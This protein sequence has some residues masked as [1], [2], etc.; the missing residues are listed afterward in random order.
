[1][2]T[3]YLCSYWLQSNTNGRKI[4]LMNTITLQRSVAGLLTLVVISIAFIT[5]QSASALSC[6][7]PSEMIKHYV[8]EASYTV[9]LIKAGA[10]E[11]E[12]HTHDQEVTVVELYKGV[13]GTNETVSFPYNET[14]SYLCAGGPVEEGVE[15]IYIMKD[16][17]VA[18]VF[19]VDSELA[20]EL[21]T[22]LGTEPTE[23]T[24]PTPEEETKTEATTGLMQRVI[25]L[26][27]Q[28][29]S[30]LTNTPL[31]VADDPTEMDVEQNYVG[32]TTKEAQL[33]AAAK[34]VLFRV[35]EID[36]E[37]QII[38]MDYRE[39]RINAATQS[40][41]VMSYTVE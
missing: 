19:A 35:V 15:A 18:Q 37:P 20:N 28:L 14:W 29:L 4:Y 3:I 22:Q 12:G 13:L 11:A 21:I 41:I 9:A 30:L 27:Q 33:Y 34:D 39:G 2:P 8:A 1:V 10:I 5:P 23:P 38:T 26:L 40:N 17:Q 6:L 36:G 25:N 7:G 31:P 32:M 16:K 24:E